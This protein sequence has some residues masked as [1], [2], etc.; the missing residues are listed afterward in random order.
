MDKS[1]SQPATLTEMI[2]LSE[3]ADFAWGLI[4]AEDHYYFNDHEAWAAE[5][6]AE[7]EAENTWLRHAKS[8]NWQEIAWLE[9]YAPW[10][11]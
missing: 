6:K 2:A 7:Q 9:Q 10:A 1:P 4:S 8:A 11:I 3:A 5:M